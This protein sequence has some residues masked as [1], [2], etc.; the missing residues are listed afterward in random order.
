MAGVT[1]KRRILL[2]FSVLAGLF[3]MHG[4]TGGDSCHGAP[5]ATTSM[6]SMASVHGEHSYPAM[7]DV[8]VRSAPSHPEPG[9]AQAGETCVPLRPEGLSSLYSAL[10]LLIVTAWQ[11]RLLFGTRLIRSHW[12]NGP[13]RTGVQVLH[14]LSISRT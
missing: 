1:G 12:P 13:P 7:P 5:P 6:T 8:N 14:A 10:F 2:L 9:H 11:P 3:L 4:I